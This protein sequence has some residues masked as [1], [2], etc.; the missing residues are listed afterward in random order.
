MNR[1]LLLALM[2]ASAPI[3]IATTSAQDAEEL[4]K[5]LQNPVASMISVPIQSNFQFR[6][7]PDRDGFSSTSNIQPVI[8]V[9]L[10]QDWNLIV[11]T[12]L[13]VIHRESYGPADGVGLGDTT[14][15]FFFT[16]KTPK[17]GFVW[18]IG[19]A[20]MWPTATSDRFGSGKWG[21]GPTALMLVQD[22]AWTVGGLANHIWSYAGP[23][24][25]KDVSATFLQPF[26]S[27]SLGKGLSL[28]LNTEASYD[29][30]A[31][32]W[33]VPINVGVG[34]V[35]KLG[36]QAMSAGL[37]FQYYAVRPTEGPRWGVRA[38]LTFLLP[39]K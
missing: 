16:P 26:L 10:N 13:P 6:G 32:Q 1:G 14:Q 23:E 3:A 29:W 31:R 22:G 8:P 7:G 9:S 34:Q 36:N 2:A 20:F 24:G 15:S 39:E 25:R 27:Y 19:P 11:R 4:S 35:F 5:K 18:G 21:A 33:T 38:T 30:I 37:G 28:S 17:N 12:I